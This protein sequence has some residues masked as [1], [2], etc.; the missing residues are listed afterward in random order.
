M[1]ILGF[2]VMLPVSQMQCFCNTLH[3][4]ERSSGS[5]A[6]APKYLVPEYCYVST[7][8]RVY[9]QKMFENGVLWKI[10]GLKGMK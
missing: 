9:W 5:R 10:F 2:T 6:V 1:L 4:E 8:P 7:K 3:E